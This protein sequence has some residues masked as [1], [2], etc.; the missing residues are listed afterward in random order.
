MKV[1]PKPQTFVQKDTHTQ[2]V[3]PIEILDQQSKYI[4]SIN[5][6]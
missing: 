3:N 4:I 2:T 1:S 5:F 6:T